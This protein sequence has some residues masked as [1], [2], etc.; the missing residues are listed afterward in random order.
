MRGSSGKKRT[1][2]ERLQKMFIN[3]KKVLD[4]LQKLLYNTIRS[5]ELHGIGEW[6]N[7][8][9]YDSDSYCQGSNPCS[10]ATCLRC[11]VA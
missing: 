2:P 9:T 5:V 4:K 7:G 3:C 11:V 6:C 8:S 10:P 1:A